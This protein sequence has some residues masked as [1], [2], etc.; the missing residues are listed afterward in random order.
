MLQLIND[1]NTAVETPI[2]KTLIVALF[3]I[4]FDGPVCLFVSQ[5]I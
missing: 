4:S 3:E 1:N 2:R 5:L